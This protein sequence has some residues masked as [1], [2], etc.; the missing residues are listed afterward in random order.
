VDNVLAFEL[1]T[2]E[3]EQITASATEHPDLFWAL[4]GGGGNFGV[5]TA[6][7][8]RLH[9][10]GAVLGGPL[11]FPMAAAPL[12]LRMYRQLTSTAPDELLAHAVLITI[13]GFGPALVIQVVY[14][15]EDLAA[16]ER[17]LVPIRR[18]GPPAVDLIGMRGYAELYQMLTP[19]IPRGAAWHDTA[20]TLRQPSD[21]A[22]DDLVVT[23]MERPSPLPVVSIHQVHG[24]ATRVAPAAT[25]FALR[26]P[27]YAVANI[28]MWLEGTGESE[29]VWSWAAKARMVRHASAGVYVNF[30]GEEGAGAVREAYRGNYAHLSAVKAHYDPDNIFH[31]NQNIAPQP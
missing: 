4:R 14:S 6:I 19:P 13:P 7:E 21:A 15:G 5:V 11:I 28:G 22:L 20:Y 24:A 18:F 10:L 26:E 8:Y 9:R 17:L 25:A 30:L 29:T 1:V 16:G 3:G 2:A 31:R 12:A 23:A 27:H